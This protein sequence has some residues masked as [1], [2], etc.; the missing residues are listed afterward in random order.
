M[1][2]DQNHIIVIYITVIMLL[3]IPLVLK[4][5]R[6]KLFFNFNFLNLV[7]VLNRSIELQLIIGLII[8]IIGILFDKVFYSNDRNGNIFSDIFIE[9][10]YCYIVIGL[11]LYLPTIGLINII[12]LV[13]NRL[14]KKHNGR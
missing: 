12:N 7:K 2:I 14:K 8:M 13:I 11:F 10:T 3:T 4:A 6:L 1:Y 5:I 9:S